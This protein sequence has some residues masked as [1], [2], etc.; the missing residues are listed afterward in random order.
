ML[1][2]LYFQWDIDFVGIPN[3]VFFF[4]R[5][6]FIFI[7]LEMLKYIACIALFFLFSVHEFFLVRYLTKTFSKHENSLQE[8]YDVFDIW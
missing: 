2:P 6:D 5:V 8:D 7:V 3:N 1:S 4:T